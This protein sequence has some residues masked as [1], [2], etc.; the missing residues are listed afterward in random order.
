ME[1][2]VTGPRDKGACPASAIRV[3]TTSHDRATWGHAFSPFSLGPVN[4]YGGFTSKNM[5][6]GWQYAKV[7]QDHLDHAGNPSPA[8]WAWA[9]DGWKMMRAVRYP[10]GKGA[11]PAYSFW[12]GEKLGYIE[13][14]KRIYFPLYRDAIRATEAFNQ[15]VRQ[16][17]SR[18]IV[19]WDFDGYDHEQQGMSL[20]DVLTNEAR[21][22]GHA[23]VL[24]A[25]LLYG[26]DVTPEFILEHA[27]DRPVSPQHFLF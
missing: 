10:R 7:Y 27:A 11:R 24:K 22:M 25:M 14:R 19:L 1:I 12:N 18:T 15:L 26:P 20:A 3:D 8:Y 5:E 2:I 21:P 6:N 16:A 13:A 9:T 17:R 23:F 4:L